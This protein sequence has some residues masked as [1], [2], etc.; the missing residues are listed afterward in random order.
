MM[1]RHILAGSALVAA[2]MLAAAGGGAPLI[3]P[4]VPR[5][6]RRIIGGFHP[7][8][9]NRKVRERRKRAARL[10]QEHAERQSRRKPAGWAEPQWARFVN[11]LTN[12]QRSKWASAGYPG[13]R[14]KEVE[15]LIAF[16]PWAFADD[17]RSAAHHDWLRMRR[18]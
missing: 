6:S 1:R 13:L 9:D 5:L 10:R 7:V 12:Y 18:T 11:R 16:F 8:G 4:E 2:G 15:K 17:S 14:H 3:L